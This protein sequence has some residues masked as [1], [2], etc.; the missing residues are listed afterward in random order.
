MQV[1]RLF[2][3]TLKANTPTLIIYFVITFV[4]AI[5]FVKGQTTV[6]NLGG[7]EIKPS[8]LIVNESKSD[9]AQGLIDY[10]DEKCTIQDIEKSKIEDALFYRQI[11]YVLYIPTD[12][13][14]QV[15]SQKAIELSSK[16]VDSIAD[17]YLAKQYVTSY[18][19]TLQG[20]L[21]YGDGDSKQIITQTAQD[22]GND[23]KVS[24]MNDSNRDYVQFYFN[25]LSYTFCSC[26]IG[27][28]GYV[29][30]VLHKREIRRRNTISPLKNV[31]M[32]LQLLLGYIVYAI[33]M[34]VVA[35]SF[36]YII[37]PDGMHQAFAPY[38]ILNTFVSLIPALG[39]AYLIGTAIK[40]L[41]I[42]NGLSNVLCLIMAFLGGSFVPQAM[43]SE[44][45]LKVSTFT[46]NYWF[47][48]VN[49]ALYKMQVFDKEHLT[50]IFSYMGI[51]ILFGLAFFL[52]ALIYSK[53][54]T[55][56]IV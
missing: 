3:K 39:L 19:S 49:D 1:F 51:E 16:S 21:K 29:M 30:F 2:F 43:L 55:K 42:Q 46:P 44:S 7:E 18:I 8:I 11:S 25:F 53:Q 38:M 47:V 9:Y 56:N 26:L 23:V 40:S 32:N 27:G 36:A 28:I 12:F 20:N 37:F 52:I 14:S 5:F 24:M 6:S 48:K 34:G 17:A 10:L 4:C 31:N 45:L 15:N 41:E 54:R 33:F 35:I 22:L 13:E 50:P